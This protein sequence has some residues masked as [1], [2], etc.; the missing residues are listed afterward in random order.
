MIIS[1]NTSIPID[2]TLTVGKL[3]EVLQALPNKEARISAT[4]T[5]HDRYSGSNTY[6]LNISWSERND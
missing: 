6:K 4:H 2:H 3:I 5:P 1:M